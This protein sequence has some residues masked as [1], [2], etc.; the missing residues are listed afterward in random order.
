M[1][2]VIRSSL[3][4]SALSKVAYVDHIV[5]NYKGGL[6]YCKEHGFTAKMYM[7]AWHTVVTWDRTRVTLSSDEFCSLNSALSVLA[8]RR[9]YSTQ[10]NWMFPCV[11]QYSTFFPSDKIRFIPYISLSLSLGLSP[12]YSPCNTSTAFGFI[13]SSKR[14]NKKN[15]RANSQGFYCTAKATVNYNR[16]FNVKYWSIILT[17]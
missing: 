15:P 2:W 13:N 4:C 7:S 3:W 10:L 14:M 5:V 16:P 1:F 11:L 9:V 12:H 8:P 6:I 17:A